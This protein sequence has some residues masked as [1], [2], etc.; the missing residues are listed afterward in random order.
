MSSGNVVFG[1]ILPRVLS[2]HWYPRAKKCS[3]IFDLGSWSWELGWNRKGYETKQFFPTSTFT[4]TS[5][6]LPESYPYIFLVFLPIPWPKISKSLS[7]T[8][9]RP[10]RLRGPCPTLAT[11]IRENITVHSEN[12][13][14]SSTKPI[15]FEWAKHVEFSF[16][17]NLLYNFP[18]SS[19]ASNFLFCSNF[20]LK[21]VLFYWKSFFSLWTLN[22]IDK[23]KQKSHKKKTDF[24]FFLEVKGIVFLK[25]K[26]SLTFVGF[27]WVLH[28]EST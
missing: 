7:I 22:P 23:F 26:F 16:V 3:N 6:F 9:L 13:E 24:T 2:V 21:I 11:W 1:F 4:V 15:G 12:H 28:S 10:V 27:D 25:V 18:N 20:L 17:Y 14:T 5:W 19:L 8:N